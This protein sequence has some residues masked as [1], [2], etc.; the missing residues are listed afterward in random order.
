MIDEVTPCVGVWIET[1]TAEDYLK[2]PDVTPCV[3]VW[4][5]T[6]RSV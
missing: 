1:M 4:I 2:M 6:P 5:E 3:G